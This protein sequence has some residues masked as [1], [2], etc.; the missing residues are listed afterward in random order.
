M[1]ENRLL[2][3]FATGKMINNLEVCS[4]I[5][6]RE[7]YVGALRPVNQYGYIRAIKTERALGK[8]DTI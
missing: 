4:I 2:Q 6:D 3:K 5:K 1:G 8:P 7:K